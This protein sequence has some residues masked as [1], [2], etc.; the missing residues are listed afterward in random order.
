MNNDDYD[1]GLPEGLDLRALS[2]FVDG[3]LPHA[4]HVA[5]EAQLERHPQAATRVGAW[6][7]QKAALRLP[8]LHPEKLRILSSDIQ[9]DGFIQKLAQPRMNH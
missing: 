1:S 3:E 2:A 8:A 9:F 4:Q 7:A 5:I 6:R